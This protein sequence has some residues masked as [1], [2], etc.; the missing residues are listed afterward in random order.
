MSPTTMSST[1]TVET[2]AAVEA[3]ATMEAASKARLPAGGK[4]S[5]ISAV[6]KATERAGAC[7]WLSMRSRRPVEGVAVVD[8]AMA[9]VEVVVINAVS[10]DGGAIDGGAIDDRSAMGDVGVVIIDH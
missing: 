6:I 5:D 9:I 3:P 8:V 1:A 4:A 10:I 2:T 7:S